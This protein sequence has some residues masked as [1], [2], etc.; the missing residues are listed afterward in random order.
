[1]ENREQMFLN[2]IVIIINNIKQV[3]HNDIDC[4]KSHYD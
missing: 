3:G 1:M 4:L 2:L